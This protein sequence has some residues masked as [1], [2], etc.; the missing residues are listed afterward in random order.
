MRVLDGGCAGVRA[1]RRVGSDGRARS[2]RGMSWYLSRERS[3]ERGW[4]VSAP[5]PKM[6][7]ADCDARDRDHAFAH[8]AVGN[9]EG[10]TLERVTTWWTGPAACPP[11][12]GCLACH[13]VPGNGAGFWTSRDFVTGPF[14]WIFRGDASMM[15]LSDLR[16]PWI[17]RDKEEVAKAV[18]SAKCTASDSSGMIPV[19]VS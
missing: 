5:G 19:A 16:V 18:D 7:V 17:R 1:G 13:F 6:G 2:G 11:R 3:T 8:A 14:D 12:E 15:F 4:K 10:C 9:A